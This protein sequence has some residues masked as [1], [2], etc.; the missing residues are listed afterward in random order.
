LNAPASAPSAKAKSVGTGNPVRVGVL[1]RKCACGTSKAQSGQT[2]EECSQRSL[3]R[4]LVVGRSDD[5]FE[6]E[7]D[8]IAE[9]V[10]GRATIDARH[11]PR[12][13]R[14]PASAVGT[15]AAES[16]A[17]AS[18][19]QAIRSSGQPIEPALRADMERRFG[20]DFGAVRIH[21]DGAAARSARDVNARAYTIGANIVFD[22]GQFAPATV[23]GRR[24]LAHELT[25]VV[26]QSGPMRQEA[27]ASAPKAQR[28]QRD[29]A[30]REPVVLPEPVT[31]DDQTHWYHDQ[32]Q[33]FY[34][35]LRSNIQWHL[36]RF[37]PR[38]FMLVVVSN[39][40]QRAQL[41][42]EKRGSASLARYCGGLVEGA[43]GATF[44][45]G[46]K[47]L[48]DY[49]E[50]YLRPIE[51]PWPHDEQFIGIPVTL[52]MLRAQF[53][54][55]E[56][57][58][59]IESLNAALRPNEI[60][61]LLSES[62]FPFS[63]IAGSGQGGGTGGS[64]AH[65]KLDPWVA[66]KKRKLQEL[67][68]QLRARTADRPTDLPDRLV[69]WFNER[70]SSWYLNVWIHFDV[71]GKIAEHKAIRLKQGERIEDLYERTVQAVHDA[72][73]G[74]RGEERKRREAEM[75]QWAIDLKK[76][77]DRAFAD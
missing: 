59:Y 26:Q 48:I 34:A 30:I 57:D 32:G 27:S 45:H 74:A 52:E 55:T 47:Q 19:E 7:A 49:F 67:I 24:L 51:Q 56:F 46:G 72:Y 11:A 1:Q 70:D 58:A 18:V 28:V 71:A 53:L 8:R 14:I 16:P 43:V 3:Q 9:Q 35:D 23:A 38:D 10:L 2:C 29:K 15:G 37:D 6:L 69:P 66:D 63:S 13:S 60:W 64:K 73:E 17:P 44:A 40:K 21:T 4:K 76:K 54:E 5:P 42:A 61:P 62:D 77:V 65:R 36:N 31:K 50:K 39:A 41:A 12:I 68:D 20:Y 33:W 25:H 75:P 22:A